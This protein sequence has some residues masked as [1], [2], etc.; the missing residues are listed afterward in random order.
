MVCSCRMFSLRLR[1]THLLGVYLPGPETP[2]FLVSPTL[3][4]FL[5]DRTGLHEASQMV[6]GVFIGELESP[7]LKPMTINLGS[8]SELSIICAFVTPSS[9][10]GKGSK[11]GEEG[12][13][14][15]VDSVHFIGIRLSG[16]IRQRS[17]PIARSLK[18]A[19]SGPEHGTPNSHWQTGSKFS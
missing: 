10:L 12:M 15:F 6:W 11:L 3:L 5:V 4:D 2:N 17:R 8:K 9:T 13:H 14:S 16:P 18:A 7:H 1:F 19:A